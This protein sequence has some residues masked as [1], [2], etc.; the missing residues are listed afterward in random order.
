M[1]HLAASSFEG[2]LVALG[3]VLLSAVSNWVQRRR[4][5][6]G[7]KDG[8]EAPRPRPLPPPSSPAGRTGVSSPQPHLGSA[9]SLSPTGRLPA[10]GFDWEK[11]LRRL[12][13]GE[14]EPTPPPE[15][16]APRQ[17]A[18][19]PPLHEQVSDRLRPTEARTQHPVVTAPSR[20]R[21]PT[22]PLMTD[23]VARLR[24]ADS[25]RQMMVAAVIL[26]PPRALE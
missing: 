25:A 7:R 20:R 23:T 19:P 4:Q 24:Q 2:L 6:Q 1:E 5:S 11:E 13:E 15:A 22:S 14:A 12:L 3:I 10:R 8:N 26:G 9:P 16:A 17:S 21:T 18:P